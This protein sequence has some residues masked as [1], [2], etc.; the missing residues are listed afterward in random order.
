MEGHGAYFPHL[1]SD[2]NLVKRNVRRP[3]SSARVESRKIL[4]IKRKS[5]IA[6]RPTLDSRLNSR[7]GIPLSLRI[8]I[9]DLARRAVSDTPKSV[10]SEETAR[11]KSGE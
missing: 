6:E 7:R 8:H 9:A 5:E 4:T 3:S 1:F 11:G 10:F 2:A